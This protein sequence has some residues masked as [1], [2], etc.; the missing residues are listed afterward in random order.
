MGNKAIIAGFPNR[1]SYAS[2]GWMANFHG[3]DRARNRPSRAGLAALRV[4]NLRI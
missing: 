2:T 1:E 4:S 3:N